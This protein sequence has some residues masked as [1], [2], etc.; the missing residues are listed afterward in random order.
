MAEN[1]LICGLKRRYGQTLGMN[2]AGEDRAEDLAHLAAVIRM[3]KPDVDLTVIRAIRRYKPQREHWSR[4][5]LTILRK[6]EAPILTAEL[7]RQRCERKEPTRP[8]T[9]ASCPYCAACM[10]CWGGWRW[11]GL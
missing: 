7:A 8:I 9:S 5:A 4:T 10:G 11:K 6:A 1:Q 2:A 3:F